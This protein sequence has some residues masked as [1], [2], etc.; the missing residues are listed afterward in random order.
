M[1]KNYWK[2]EGTSRYCSIAGLQSEEYGIDALN[3]MFPE[4]EAN[5][6]NFVLFST[7]GVHGT[8]NTIEDEEQEIYNMGQPIGITFLIVQPR[9]VSLKYGNCK[10]QNKED[11]D[12]L[13][14]LRESSMKAIAKIGFKE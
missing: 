3:I 7:S 12:Y 8:Y 10:P 11:I 5:E 1:E 2:L 6:L 9:I 14:K 13:K 4:G